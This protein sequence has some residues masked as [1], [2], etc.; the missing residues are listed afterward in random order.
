[1]PEMGVK[2]LALS[3]LVILLTAPLTQVASAVT[4]ESGVGESNDNGADRGSK[5]TEAVFYSIKSAAEARRDEVFSQ[6]NEDLLPSVLSDVHEALELMEMAEGSWATDMDA[7]T[8]LYMQAIRLFRDSWRHF[9][10]EAG[11]PMGDDSGDPVL[12]EELSETLNEEILIAKQQLLVRFQRNFHNRITSLYSYIQDLSGVMDPEDSANIGNALMSA[13]E[14]L[15]EVQENMTDCGMD[16]ILTKLDATSKEL[17][18]KFRSLNDRE[19]ADLIVTVDK[20]EGKV[21]KMTEEN[22]KNRGESEDDS[23]ESEAGEEP[24]GNSDSQTDS[25]N[26]TEDDINDLKEQIKKSLEDFKEKRSQHTSDD[27]DERESSHND[28][29]DERESSENSGNGNG[30]GNE[31]Q[32]KS[33]SN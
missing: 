21:Q 25:A 8:Q 31:N 7:A 33:K 10:D 22:T 5:V 27:N 18:D 26:S 30:N 23:D 12:E 17:E 24:K 6:I 15:I 14:E 4:V 11:V 32:G 1:V 28:D 19:A 2:I 3:L 29:D 20:L 16:D 13:E 9:D